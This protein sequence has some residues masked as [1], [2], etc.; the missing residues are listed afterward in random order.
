[1][2]RNLEPIVAEQ[3]FLKDLVPEHLALLAGCA[4]NV[5]FRPGDYLIREGQD[6]RSFFLLRQ[7]RV[8]IEIAAPGR[9][10][11]PIETIGEGDVLGKSWLIPPYRWRFD[12]RA[13]ELTRAIALDG[14]CLRAKCEEDR[15]LVYELLRRFAQVMVE[16]LGATRMQLL[17]LCQV[18]VRG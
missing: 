3:P 8:S 6:A 7:G 10:P 13:V 17:D 2:I 1:M 12:G 16:R 14:E 5:V 9:G 11:I 4:S 18:H 15:D